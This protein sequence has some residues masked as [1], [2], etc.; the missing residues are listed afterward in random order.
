MIY[1]VGMVCVVRSFTAALCL[2]LLGLWGNAML[3]TRCYDEYPLMDQNVQWRLEYRNE[4]FGFGIGFEL[5]GFV[6]PLCTRSVIIFLG[7]CFSFS[8]LAFRW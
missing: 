2:P 7:I 4:R 5:V 6:I 1:G 8:H 3:M